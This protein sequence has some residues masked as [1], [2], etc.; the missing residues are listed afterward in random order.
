MSKNEI[1]NGIFFHVTEKF[2]RFLLKMFESI[3]SVMFKNIFLQNFQKIWKN[4]F[5]GKPW[6][7]HFFGLG[8]LSA[9]RFLKIG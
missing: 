9:N 7:G 6:F 5:F 3:F 1:L 4:G 2:S 8:V